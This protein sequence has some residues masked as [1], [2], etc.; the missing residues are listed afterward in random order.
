MPFFFFFILL[1]TFFGCA[2][3]QSTLPVYDEQLSLEEQKIQSQL[4]AESWLNAYLDFSE[5]GYRILFGAADLCLNEDQIYD[6]GID[7]ATKYNGPESIREEIAIVLDLDENLRVVAVGQNTPAS[8][9]G[10]LRGD[11]IIKIDNEKTSLK[12]TMS[13]DVLMLNLSLRDQLLLES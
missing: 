11:K 13:K 10:F 2:Q 7:I 4:F 5:I 3:P 1:F 6:I 12:H 8:E 9:S